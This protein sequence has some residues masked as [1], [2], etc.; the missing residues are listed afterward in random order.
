MH[1]MQS[2]YAHSYSANMVADPLKC[3]NNFDEATTGLSAPDHIDRTL[4]L[5]STDRIAA[6]TMQHVM[7]NDMAPT[8]LS[9]AA[10]AQT[11]APVHSLQQDT[12]HGCG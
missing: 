4:T 11:L 6:H 7:H 9:S 3:P 12:S 10:V 1:E 2:A 8:H 5:S